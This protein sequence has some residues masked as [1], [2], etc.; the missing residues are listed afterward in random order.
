MTTPLRAKAALL[1]AM[2]VLP[3]TAVHGQQLTPNAYAPSPVGTNVALIADN[4]SVGDVA[5][6]PSLPVTGLHA[7]INSPAVGYARTLGILGHYANVGIV[8]PYVRGDLT[9][10]YLGQYQ[11]AAPHG[12]RRSTI[13]SGRKSIRR[14]GHDATAVRRLS[15]RRR[16]LA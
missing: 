4:Y 15:V 6:D 11:A 7:T 1:L 8:V 12:L 3:V 16:L 13:A 9:G 14:A 5:L 2:T 10:Y